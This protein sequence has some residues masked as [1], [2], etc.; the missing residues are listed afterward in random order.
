MLQIISVL[1]QLVQI[2]VN[3]SFRFFFQPL[4]YDLLADK[5]QGD[6]YSSEQEQPNNDNNNRRKSLTDPRPPKYEVALTSEDEADWQKLKYLPLPKVL[7]EFQSDIS[8]S[9]DK[10]LRHSYYGNMSLMSKPIQRSD[11]KLSCPPSAAE[12]ASFDRLKA[13]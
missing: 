4:V 7:S 1:Q 8:R 10:G 12:C 3:I 6:F 13:S 5:I 2:N 11:G 9:M